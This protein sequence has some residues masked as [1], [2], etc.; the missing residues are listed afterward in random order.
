MM[1]SHLRI[2]VNQYDAANGKHNFGFRSTIRFKYTQTHCGL[3]TYTY[4]SSK[5]LS[6]SSLVTAYTQTI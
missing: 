6:E 4:T 1:L 3:Y 5:Y 2:T